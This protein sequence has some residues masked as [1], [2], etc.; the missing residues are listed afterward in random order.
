MA[1]QPHPETVEHAVEAAHAPEAAA[2]GADAAAHGA[3]G[4]GGFP[5]FDP[6]TFGT[7]LFWFALTF[8]ALY[9][10]VS[11]VLLPG[12]ARVLEARAGQIGRDRESAAIKTTEAEE[13]RASMERATA[14][15]KADARKLVDDMRADVMAKINAEQAAAEAELVKAADAAEARIT[16]MR[17]TAIAEVRASADDLGR[18]IADKLAP[19]AASAPLQRVAG[20]A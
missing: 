18:A 8:G 20:D 10:I 9:L 13:A 1:A 5:P 12:V 2:H 11:R 19:A 4:A 17:E 6:L 7:Q 16:A 3:E 14:K 15:A